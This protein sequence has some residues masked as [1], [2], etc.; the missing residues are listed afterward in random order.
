ME[1]IINANHFG[2]YGDLRR[3]AEALASRRT[4]IYDAPDDSVS[5]GWRAVERSPSYR[6]R[7]G[8]GTY[9]GLVFVG[10]QLPEIEAVL[11]EHCG[12]TVKI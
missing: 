11:A 7:D 1:R 2:I 3:Q 8:D 9:A 5:Y 10:T 4:L 12:D 6:R